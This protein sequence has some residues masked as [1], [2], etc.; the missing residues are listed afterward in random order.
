MCQRIFV[1][2]CM[3]VI[4]TTTYSFLCGYPSFFS[5]VLDMGM[6]RM[7]IV[8][9]TLF[10]LFLFLLWLWWDFSYFLY[11]YSCGNSKVK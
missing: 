3:S 2:L 5:Y 10:F 7:I 11:I 6:N 9:A 4:G 1:M 8:C